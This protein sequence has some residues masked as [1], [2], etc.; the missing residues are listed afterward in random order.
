LWKNSLR[1]IVGA[2]IYAPKLLHTIAWYNTD[3]MSGSPLICMR[4]T[5][6]S[7]GVDIMAHSVQTYDKLKIGWPMQL[8]PP[9]AALS[10]PSSEPSCTVRIVG[11]EKAAVKALKDSV[12]ADVKKTLRVLAGD[13]GTLYAKL[14]FT[15][16]TDA[17]HA[18]RTIPGAIFEP[19]VKKDRGDGSDGSVE[20]S[21]SDTE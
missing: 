9:G 12:E 11:H 16:F 13:D 3:A 4:P 15:H 20:G 7:L 1:C 19:A 10:V 14:Q 21:D 18:V 2:R 17:I 5:A 8:W 6:A